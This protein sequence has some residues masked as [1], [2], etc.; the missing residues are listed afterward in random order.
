MVNLQLSDSKRIRDQR[1]SRDWAG[2]THSPRTHLEC[3][4][5]NSEAEKSL[6]VDLGNELLLYI[7][8]LII[9]LQS[10]TVS[11]PETPAS[12]AAHDALPSS[13]GNG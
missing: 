6:V 5:D 7:P 8:G 10:A 1:Y 11:T 12:R 3:T 13:P 9:V 2:L 4:R